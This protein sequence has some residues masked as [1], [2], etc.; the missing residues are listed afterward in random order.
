MKVISNELF[1]KSSYQIL[2]ERKKKIFF[3]LFFILTYNHDVIYIRLHCQWH[4][5]RRNLNN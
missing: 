4:V 2:T 5:K 1:L 3:F